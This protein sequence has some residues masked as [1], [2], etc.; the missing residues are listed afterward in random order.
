MV[1]KI[2]K[3][4]NLHVLGNFGDMRIGISEN[5]QKTNFSSYWTEFPIRLKFDEI[6]NWIQFFLKANKYT[7]II[8]RV[9][10]NVSI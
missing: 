9:S 5:F 2:E 6:K 4:I 7:K 8:M 1:Q 10:R 3:Y